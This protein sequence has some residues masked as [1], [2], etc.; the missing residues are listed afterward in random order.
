V[1]VDPDAYKLVSDGLI[2]FF[3][4]T[5]TNSTT[6]E[7]TAFDDLSAQLKDYLT[8]DNKHTTQIQVAK[9][10]A[11]TC[12]RMHEKARVGMAEDELGA[13][14][15]D[16]DTKAVK[17]ASEKYALQQ[18]IS[19]AERAQ[20]DTY[21]AIFSQ[22]ASLKKYPT[23]T[24]LFDMHVLDTGV[25]MKTKLT[26]KVRA[27]ATRVVAYYMGWVPQYHARTDG[28]PIKE[29]ER[30]N[31]H[32]L[33]SKFELEMPFGFQNREAVMKS[34]W[35]K[36]IEGEY[37]YSSTSCSH[38]ACPISP[39]I[40]RM[41][42][43]RTMKIKQISASLTSVTF[44]G[45]VLLGGSL[46]T[47]INNA[48]TIPSAMNIPVSVIMYFAAVRPEH[49]FDDGDSTELG[50]LAMCRLYRHRAHPDILR[51]EINELISL[52]SVLRTCQAKYRFLDEYLYHIMG[53]R[54][55]RGA[56]QTGFNVN[57]NLAALTTNEAG[58]IARSFPMLLMSNATGE[59]AVDEFFNS[60]PALGDMDDE[61]TWFRPTMV[62]I[63][64]EL[65]SK[66]AYGVKVRASIGGSV[67]ILDMVSDVI[68]IL[69]YITTGRM[70]FA[71][72]LIG[73][74]AANLLVQL[75]IVWIQTHGLTENKW[76]TMAVEML[77][78]VLFIKPALDSWK[79]ASGADKPSGASLPPL[80]EMSFSKATEMVFEAV[81]GFC[82]QSLAI[83]TAKDVSIRAI[84]SLLIS[85]ASTGLTATTIF[86]DNDVEPGVRKRNPVWT[87]AIPNQGRGLAF[88]TVFT[89]CTLHVVA[90]GS[91][92]ALMYIAN[93]RYLLIY[94]VV[95]YSL[96]FIY[97]AAR[98]DVI[99][100]IAMPPTA[101]WVFSP[102]IRIMIKV[103]GDFCGTPINR[104]PIFLGGSYYIINLISAQASVLFAVYLYDFEMA[105]VV[106]TEKINVDTLWLMALILVGSWCAAM[107]Y[108]LVKIA[109]P[110]HRHTF[111][112][113]V[114]GRQCVHEYFTKGTN[115]ADKLLIFG[116]NRLLWE[117]DIGSEVKKFTMQHWAEWERDKPAWFTATLKAEVPDN[118]FPREFLAGLGGV[119]RIRRGSAAESVRDSFRMIENGVASVEMVADEDVE[120]VVKKVEEVKQKAM[121]EE[122]VIV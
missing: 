100:F 119:N 41:D 73:M 88:A 9:L 66:V 107:T 86:Y 58:Q 84:V 38:P 18:E 120:E 102:I 114:S 105:D 77:T 104:L 13:G 3:V 2:D 92:T 8:A 52:V 12:F 23:N 95:D 6:D 37:F 30:E 112:S 118:Y 76:R 81:P 1:S 116:N 40:V 121:I 94:I 35:E 61:F 7:K 111:W 93:P 11:A 85:A 106:D 21:K 19:P 36:P 98:K 27:P 50:Q 45:S 64:N 29:I 59:S 26:F 117:S 54:T 34:I 87:G 15:F 99:V 48:V 33:V 80:H 16:D 5:L 115:S 49:E 31:D 4:D 82:L 67:S 65:M 24:K 70:R 96:Y 43:A 53:N 78:T 10:L 75:I 46:P 108:F 68:M 97:C 63:A 56:A 20:L 32:S 71:Y 14:Q 90:K 79:V 122:D 72:L 83:L 22:N 113:P 55:K 110:T 39:G 25:G 17:L 74:V 109:T 101:S 47:K 28:R 42:I 69:E 89:F 51:K 62:A 57:T 60:F 103:T 44:V 91:A